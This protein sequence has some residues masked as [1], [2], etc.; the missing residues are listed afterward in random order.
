MQVVF[1]LLR[2]VALLSVFALGIDVATFKVAWAGDIRL[3]QSGGGFTLDITDAPSDSV[4]LATRQLPN[5]K[6]S[7]RVALVVGNSAYESVPELANPRNDATDMAK[8]LAALDF[9]VVQGIDLDLQGLRKTVRDFANRMQGA[10]I[11]VFF[12]AGHG[13]QVNGKNYMVPIDAKLASYI[14]LEFEA[15]PM[16]LVLSTMENSVKTNIV[17]LDACRDNPLA[18]NLAR[19]MGTRSS[20][21]GRGLAPIGSGIG[22]LVSFAT[23]PGN[24]ALDGKGRNSPFTAALLKHLGT[25]GEDITRNMVRVRRDVLAATDGKQVPWEHSSLT[26]E[27]I[28][29]EK[30][31]KEEPQKPGAGLEITFWNSIRSADRSEYFETYLSRYPNGIF[32]EIAKLRI[33]EFN[34][35]VAADPESIVEKIAPP[36]P[37][38]EEAANGK[39]NEVELASLP[40]P[41][42]S[43][44]PDQQSTVAE[45]TLKRELVRAVQREL[46]RLGCKAGAADGQWGKNSSAALKRYGRH[47]NL[48]LASLEPTN[49]LLDQLNEQIRRVC[50]LICRSGY[51]KKNEACVRIIRNP[52]SENQGSASVNPSSPSSAKERSTTSEGQRPDPV[53]YS[54][55]VW[56][57]GIGNGQGDR[58]VSL[59]KMTKYGLLSCIDIGD[60]SGFEK[61][62]VLS[63]GVRRTCSWD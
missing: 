8:K 48:K 5:G 28:L 49:D 37:A 2:C 13:L 35:K 4:G 38:T 46:N 6:T 22:T 31:R 3:A 1:Q 45:E 12:Y 62:P 10:D 51:E 57:I 39:P 14:D 19:S 27:V 43:A 20:A 60:S 21:V 29:K 42:A 17:F 24:V 53:Q 23:Q 16:D 32:A 36:T 47:G 15:M 58:V 34:K 25:P 40:P 41:D 56:S 18:R 9:E 33:A 11:A 44:T 7:R 52:G 26:G 55:Q 59:S 63:Q 30:P 61:R 54:K 50:P